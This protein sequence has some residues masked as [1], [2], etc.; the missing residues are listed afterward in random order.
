MERTYGKA[1][2]YSNYL[3]R[4]GLALDLGGMFVTDEGR[5]LLKALNVPALDESAGDVF[6]IVLR[7]D[8]PFAYAQALEALSRH[9]DD[10]MLVEP[11]FRLEQLM[12]IAELD[13]ITRVLT[14]PRGKRQE[15]EVLAVG[16]AG[17]PEHR[18]LEVRVAT[19]L[20]DRYLIPKNG[21]ALMLGAS[22]GG[23]GK[24][25]STLTTLGEV[26][27]TALAH[28]HE[29]IWA[30]AERLEPRSAVKAST[31]APNGAGQDATT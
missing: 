17:L 7:A 8:N 30:E 26:A 3:I 1:E 4:T 5:A 27:S 20:H 18:E 25:V 6:E 12:D 23:I 24:K 16:L 13:N 10:C 29:S 19:S 31:E 14:G 21:A 28:A 9:G 22:L 15:R 2:P 11:Y